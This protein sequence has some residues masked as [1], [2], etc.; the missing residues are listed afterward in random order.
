MTFLI[1]RGNT[2][3]IDWYSLF[4]DNGR[5]QSTNLMATLL[6][7]KITTLFIT[8]FAL[9]T[10]VYYTARDASMFGFNVFVVGDA[11]S[12][13]LPSAINYVTSDLLSKGVVFINS[14]QIPLAILVDN[15]DIV[16]KSLPPRYIYLDQFITWQAANASCYPNVLCSAADY[17]PNGSPVAGTLPPGTWAPVNVTNQWIY[18]GPS[19]D[20]TT[21]TFF[22]D[23]YN[24]TFPSTMQVLGGV[25][26]LCCIAPSSTP[27]SPP[28]VPTAP[29]GR[30]HV[31]VYDDPDDPAQITRVVLIACLCLGLGIV[32][33]IG[34]GCFLGRKSVVNIFKI[35]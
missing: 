4:R 1:T 30:I 34:V 33:G 22:S 15:S 7:N 23:K 13:I 5:F 14:S 6:T 27:T 28:T 18:L 31:T 3:Q 24:N 8:G 26:L 9:D 29:P 21:C 19:S 2:C 20:T 35:L 25:P 17:C 12:V 16:R 32:V 11:T 10:S